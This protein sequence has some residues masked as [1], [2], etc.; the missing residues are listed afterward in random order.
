MRTLIISSLAFFATAGT[1]FAAP[2]DPSQME[3]THGPAVMPAASVSG[4]T[5]TN[6][7]APATSN[8]NGNMNEGVRTNEHMGEPVLMHNSSTTSNTSGSHPPIRNVM[9]AI[10][11]GVP[12]TRN[13]QQQR[14][15]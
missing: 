9:A 11:H 14:S 5:H 1:A 15:P 6:T 10:I 4:E 12:G 13:M 2:L 7:G 8:G 3:M